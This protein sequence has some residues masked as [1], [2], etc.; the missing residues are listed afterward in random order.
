MY[1]SGRE[2]SNN[3]SMADDNTTII[4]LETSNLVNL[5]LILEN[6]SKASML[7]CNFSKITIMLIGPDPTGTIDTAGFPI[8]KRIKHLGLDI[9]KGLSNF[10]AYLNKSWKK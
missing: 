8:S 7:T 10:D 4:K 9:E 5:R 6:F 2:T 3:E 1:E